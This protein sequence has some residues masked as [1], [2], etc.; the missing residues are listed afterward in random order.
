MGSKIVPLI[1]KRVIPQSWCAFQDKLDLAYVAYRR[2][3]GE[4]IPNSL[5]RAL[6]AAE[7]R[8]FARHCGIDLIA[9]CRALHRYIFCGEIS[10]ASTIAQQLVRVLTGK[11]ERTLN[12]KIREMLLAIIVTQ[13]IPRRDIPGLY[14]SVAYF[15]WRM[16]GLREA[17]DRLGLKLQTITPYQAALIVARLKYPEP[18]VPS[19]NRLRQIERRAHYIAEFLVLGLGSA[20]SRESQVISDAAI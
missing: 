15:G 7:D 18:R 9:V 8:R 19:E 5:V 14:L 12:R 13:M 16:N 4:G 20:S 10:G 1:G 17:C 6:V 2:T 3:W 11:Y